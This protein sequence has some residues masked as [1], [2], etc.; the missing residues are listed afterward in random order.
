MR[1]LISVLIVLA[2]MVGAGS[3]PFLQDAFAFLQKE[4]IK[5]LTDPQPSLESFTRKLTGR[6]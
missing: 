3:T 2:G 4:T 5:K 1:D 6:D